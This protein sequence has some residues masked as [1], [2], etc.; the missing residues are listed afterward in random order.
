MPLSVQTLSKSV[1]FS[2]FRV[3]Q[4]GVSGDSFNLTGAVAFDSV[5][6][7][8]GGDNFTFNSGAILN[9]VLDGQ[10]G[11][12]VLQGLAIDNVTLTGSTANGEFN[13]TENSINGSFLGIGN[14]VGT[15][16][17]MLTG[18]SAAATSTWALNG[19]APTYND[20]TFSLNFTGFRTLQ[21]QGGID[22]FNVTGASDFNLNG[23]D[24]KSVV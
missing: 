3:L 14:I 1:P 20:G 24:R 13:G 9:G 19:V 2:G 10:G 23:G 22:L 4:G 12:D 15:T 7:G 8:A 21:G 5:L 11:A 18:E 17:G 16:L 6:G